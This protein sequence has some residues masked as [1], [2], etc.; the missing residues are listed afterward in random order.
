MIGQF[1]EMPYVLFNV[2]LDV[3]HALSISRTQSP[4]LL[5]ALLSLIQLLEITAESMVQVLK[6][7]QTVIPEELT[8]ETRVSLLCSLMSLLRSCITHGLTH[9]ELRDVCHLLLLSLI[10]IP[11]PL[12]LLFI[13]SEGSRR[14]CAG[15]LTP[16][17]RF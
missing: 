16:R 3:I 8:P 7:A 13:G 1:Q 6:I 2:L 4:I 5:S 10:I 14:S 9:S 11:L 12:F 17:R 15:S